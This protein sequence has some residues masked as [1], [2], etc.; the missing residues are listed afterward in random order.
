M[1]QHHHRAD[2]DTITIEKMQ[3]DDNAT[4]QPTGEFETIQADSV[5]LALGQDVDLDLLQRLPGL[6]IS[7]GRSSGR[8]GAG[9]RPYPGIF[10]GGDMTGGARTVTPRSA[11]A[12]AARAIDAWLRGRPTHRAPKLR[13]RRSSAS[14]PGTTPMR[15]RR[16]GRYSTSSGASRPSTRWSAASRGQR[17]VRGAALHVLRQ[18]LRMRHLLRVCPDN[19][20]IKLGPGLGFEFNLDYCK[21]CG[22]CVAECPCGSIRMEPEPQ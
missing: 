6:E 14:I 15:R 12:K 10:A 18:L 9:H 16:C 21:G 17:A 3:L 20:V 1:A 5:V 2:D 11:T 22:L 13:W 8:P 7:G 4:P 19:A